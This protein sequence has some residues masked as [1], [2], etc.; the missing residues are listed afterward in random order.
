MVVVGEELW[1][2]EV[3]FEQ[4]VG[5]VWRGYEYSKENA[6]RRVKGIIEAVKAVYPKLKEPRVIIRKVEW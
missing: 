2:Y 3:E 4:L 5:G 1:Y 6:E